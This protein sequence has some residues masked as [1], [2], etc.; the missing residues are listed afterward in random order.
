MEAVQPLINA[1]V[2]E[3][4][5]EAFEDARKVDALITSGVKT[6]DEMERETPFLGVPFSAKEAVSVKGLFATGGA[7][8]RKGERA[9]EDCDAV[10]LFRQ[11]GGIPLVVTNTSE[12]CLWWETYN[13]LHG[14]TN[15]P[16]DTTRTPGGSSGGESSLLTAA[17]SVIGIGTDLGGSIR[18]PALFS[19]IFGHK[20]STGVVSN[21][22][23]Y[24]VVKEAVRMMIG[25]GPMC[26]YAVDLLPMM[27][28]LSGNKRDMLK[29]DEPVN[30]KK[31]RV[32]YM[33]DD[34]GYPFRTP[35]SR[36]IKKALRKA[37]G[38]FD[39]VCEIKPQ[40]IFKE[41]LQDAVETWV[42]V[43]EA[44]NDQQL[45]NEIVGY[46]KK[47]KFGKEVLKSMA[48]KSK[49]TFPVI[50]LAMLDRYIR[51][52]DVKL[53]DPFFKMRDELI[54]EF[55][56]LLG[57][58]GV[59]LYPTYPDTAPYHNEMMFRPFNIGYSVIFNIL[60]LPVTQCPMGLGDKGLPLG[61]QIVG[62]M[63]SDRVTMAAAKELER[64]FGGWISPCDVRKSSITLTEI[65]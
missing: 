29:L 36:E 40:K 54:D 30:I 60:G 20:P 1:Y 52:F 12:M 51:N 50:V 64:V 43:I 13:K 14:K 32:F 4:F 7:V 19:G 8:F 18:I 16:Y 39:T 6:V 5:Q 35:V 15:N 56:E 61:I 2:D 63:N 25:T 48:G 47:L 33:E 26:R 24:P 22:N 34:G 10:R 42:C 62:A 49:H 17:A 58:D 21:G 31:V 27:K 45:C 3:R 44:L 55:N 28:V 23:Q 9:E 65:V 41:R 59:F 11:A 38:H 53:A 57:E 46:Q 37:V